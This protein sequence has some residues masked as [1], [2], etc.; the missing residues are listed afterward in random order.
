LL[1]LFWSVN[2]FKQRQE[3]FP[4]RPLAEL[5]GPF[6]SPEKAAAE[7]EDA[8]QRSDL[9]R[10]EHALVLLARS[11]GARQ[12]LEQ[13]WPYGCRNGAFGGHAAIV[14][15]NCFRVLETIGWQH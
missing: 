5:Q 8:M 1:P 10:A 9:D 7:F 6:R 4:G 11:Q 2:A 12:T 15:A 3:D 14:I 13:L